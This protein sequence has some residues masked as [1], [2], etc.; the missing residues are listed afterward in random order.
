MNVTNCGG[1]IS[2]NYAGA[3]YIAS[4]E[5]SNGVLTV[6]SPLG[7]AHTSLVDGEIASSASVA[8]TL[9]RAIVEHPEERNALLRESS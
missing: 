9:L 1:R 8:R 5:V 6:T 2:L 7:S 4:Y 3:R